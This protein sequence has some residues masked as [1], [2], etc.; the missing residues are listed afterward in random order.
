M[1]QLG[2]PIEILQKLQIYYFNE[3][4]VATIQGEQHIGEVW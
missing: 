4:C 2:S 1:Y 3:S